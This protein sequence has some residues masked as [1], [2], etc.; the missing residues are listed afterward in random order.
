[1]H[2][3]VPS[4]GHRTSH[5]SSATLIALL[6]PLHATFGYASMFGMFSGY[7]S[8]DD[9]PM[10]EFGSKGYT[11]GGG[12]GGGGFFDPYENDYCD[13]RVS[14]KGIYALYDVA[15]KNFPYLNKPYSCSEQMIC[16]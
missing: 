9:Y 13:C 5:H 6:T 8:E 12:R 7:G 14:Q 2:G 10:P 1:M 16:D 4:K 15:E 3:L 11:G